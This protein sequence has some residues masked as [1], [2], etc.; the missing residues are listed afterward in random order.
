M[1]L[2]LCALSLSLFPVACAKTQKA[3]RPEEVAAP[4]APATPDAAGPSAAIDAAATP[5][6]AATPD[7]AAPPPDA[8]G[9]DAVKTD[10]TTDAAAEPKVLVDQFADLRVLSYRVPGWDK[11]D[12]KIRVLVYHFTQA[13]LAG[14][15]IVWDQNHPLG[16]TVRK[17][18]EAIDRT[19]KGD[20]TTADYQ[21]F[22]TYLKRVWFSNGIYH[23]YSNKK[24]DPGFG[25]DVFAKLV[26]GSDPA[27]FPLKD[28][29]TPAALVERL[30]PLLFD[31]TVDP[32]GVSLDS[33]GDLIA[34]SANNYY[35]RGLTQ[36][37]VEAFYADRKKAAGEHPVMFGLNSKLVKNADGKIEERVWKVGGMYGAAMDKMVGHLEAALPFTENG[38]QKAWL[39]AL[40][41]F[42]RSG[43]LADFDAFN[44]AWV[45]DTG[46]TVDL[47]HGFIETYGD[48]LDMRGMYESIVQVKDPESTGR[49]AT[50]S[51]QAQWFEDH[52]P[53]LPQHKKANVTGISARVIDTVTG[54]GDAG[55][56]SP[57][58]VNLPN[59]DW[60]RKEVGSKSVTL[61]NL[62]SAHEEVKKTSGVL[63]E[64][65]PTPEALARAKKWAGL[66]D[67]LEVDMHEVIGHASGQLEPGVATPTD[68]LKNYGSCLEEARADLV[69]LYFL[70]DAKLA[71]LGLVADPDIAKTAYEVYITNGLLTQLARIPLGETIQEAHMRNRHLI[72][73][74]VVDKGGP[75]VVEKIDKEP[76]KTAYVVRD[77]DKLRGLFGDLLKEIQRI[78]SQGDYE[79]GK[80]LVEGFGV[81]ID[82]A[83]H[84]QIKARWDKLGVA[85]FTGFVNPRIVPV[86]EGGEIVDAKIEYVGD[87][88]AQMREY[89]E[90][91]SFLPTEN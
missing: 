38:P 28:G 67:K 35:A 68:T 27:A 50:I 43:D 47:I 3:P 39:E 53:Y 23:H 8:A 4:T 79:A 59:S 61:G 84:A 80:A 25:K 51:G 20:K 37:E 64:F 75:A 36:K 71:E 77:F 12:P 66:A 9:G 74:W 30:A 41:K 85:P 40:I 1:R 24:M 45:K 11:L 62:M 26:E 13:A 78:K 73:Q 42:Y 56:A 55:P 72:A 91:Y 21:A 87:F 81:K 6:V 70:P 63:E 32:V 82:P 33:G 14:R 2:W 86:M 5:D 88:A 44:V 16:L 76:G 34:A 46:S 48:P 52:M 60:I 83:L 29:E 57:I 65:A 69:A 19:Y 54:V 49:I 22:E 17:T 7:A 10:A 89:A 58:G 90:R 31:P 18:L 15:D